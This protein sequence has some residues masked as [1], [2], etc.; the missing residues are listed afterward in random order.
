ML[1]KFF[2][3]SLLTTALFAER[4]PLVS[5][6]A[7]CVNVT[8]VHKS[9]LVQAEYKWKPVVSEL[10]PQVGIFITSLG[11]TFLYGGISYDILIGKKVV[12][13][14]SF[15][16]GLYYRGE[17][18]DLGF[19]LEFKSAMDIAYRFKNE[20]RIGASFYHLSNAHLSRRN[21]GVNIL[22]FYYAFPLQS[23][24]REKCK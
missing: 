12:L 23:N 22:A 17:G 1:K 6:G 9:W 24:K 11:S 14:P 2:A 4:T 10:R 13:T 5:I 16:P 19:P 18:K 15:C 7:G 20:S 8:G 21:P 3:L